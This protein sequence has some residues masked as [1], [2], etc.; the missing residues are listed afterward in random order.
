MRKTL[1]HIV[2]K[3]GSH[4]GGSSYGLLAIK[5]VCNLS[6]GIRKNSPLDREQRDT[7]SQAKV[8]Q[9][10]GTDQRCPCLGVLRIRS[11]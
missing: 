8:D 7:Y 5:S 11:V 1:E 9:D 4:R 6:T 3:T 2:G 10:I